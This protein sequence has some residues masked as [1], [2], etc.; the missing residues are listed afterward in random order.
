MFPPTLAEQQPH[1]AKNK[2]PEA[3]VDTTVEDDVDGIGS[4]TGIRRPSFSKSTK[5][6]I[7][8]HEGIHVILPIAASHATSSGTVS[9]LRRCLVDLSLPTAHGA[10]FDALYVKNIKDSLILCGQV[11]G[12]LHITGVENSVVVV[13]CRQFRMHGSKNVDIYLHSTSRPIF[14]DCEGLR[15]APLPEIYVSSWMD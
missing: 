3:I 12:A 7:S 14:E 2:Q 5:V 1:D 4:G 9:N 10:P 11:A 13:A 8:K 6:T 15:F